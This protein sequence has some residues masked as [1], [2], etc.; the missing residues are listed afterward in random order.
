MLEAGIG[1]KWGL[2]NQAVRQIVNAKGKFLKEIK[3]AAT[4]NIWMVK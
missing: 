4:V 3:C 1:Q 2:L